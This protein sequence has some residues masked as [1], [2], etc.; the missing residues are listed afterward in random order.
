M[1]RRWNTDEDTRLRQLY[2]T[3]AP[4]AVIATQLGRSEDAVN[5]RRAALGIAPRRRSRE[6]SP[7]ADTVLREAVR[8]GVPTTVL[9]QRSHRPVE[10][11]RARRRRLGLDRSAA[12]RYTLE[13]D[14]AIRAA[15]ELGTSLDELAGELG[16][17]SEAVLLRARRI[18]LHRPARRPRWTKSEDATLRDGYADGLTCHQIARALDQRTPT[19]VA[20]RAHKLGLASYARRWSAA[21]DQRLGRLLARHTIDDAARTLGRTPE[22]IRRRARK[23]GLDAKAPPPRARSSA[24]WSAQ[25]DALLG[26]YAALSP[27]VLGALL[28][29]SDHAIVARLRKLGLRAGRQRSPH[30]PSP[31]N[32][33]L[34][35]GERALVDRELRNRG[36]RAL[37]I[38]ERRLGHSGVALQ[39]AANG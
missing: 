19:A 23:L 5:A 9:A 8:A 10:Q 2:A 34:S 27:G 3:G 21:D 31:R 20:A 16:R 15:W 29:R 39:K 37:S 28:G 11:L 14:H 24:R 26:L 4:L 1:A 18:G 32:G 30:H 36:E 12:R 6:W 22:A 17:N 35:P 7:L 13:D 25:D 38:L 33:G